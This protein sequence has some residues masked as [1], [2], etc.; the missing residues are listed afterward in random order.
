MDQQINYAREYL[1][2]LWNDMYPGAPDA[3]KAG[4]LF[5]V[6]MSADEAFQLGGSEALRRAWGVITHMRPE[7]RELE[8]SN[9]LIPANDLKFLNPPVY[10]HPDYPIYS[11]GLNLVIAPSGTGKTFFVMLLGGYFIRVG[12]VVIFIVGE[13]LH[14]LAPRW[15]VL[16]A[17]MRIGE[18]AQNLFFYREPVQFLD[19]VSVEL[20]HSNLESQNLKPDFIVVDT[21]GR[22]SVG[23][24]ENSNKEVGLF[25]G[26]VDSVRKLYDCGVILVHHTGKNG[27]MRGAQKLFDS[28]DS[29][30]M[31][32]KLDGKIKVSN[33]FDE[34]GKNKHRQEH[35][36]MYFELVPRQVGEWSSAVLVPS[37][38]VIHTPKE[39]GKLNPT[40]Q[41]I[42][43]T[44]DA[45]ESGL[46][47]KDIIASTSI[48]QAT[49]YRVL[50]QLLRS[51][52]VVRDD[53]TERYAITDDGKQAW[54]KQLE[55]DSHDS[56]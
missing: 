18:E 17:D 3:E 34:G 13:G 19:P 28:C 22:C 23:L 35:D 36:P 52:Y 5:E 44:L 45:Y 11:K 2:Q 50:N 26:A 14:G 38:A 4:A 54:L 30:L 47:V 24:E 33:S 6:L 15:E 8:L 51:G 53:G 39:T 31:L 32:T 56:H 20:F 10:V 29:A 25:I 43:E 49:V 37:S 42:L 48:S 40:Q 41:T 21:M 27:Q 46:K 16:K 1:R 9:L 55:T 12:L 7:A